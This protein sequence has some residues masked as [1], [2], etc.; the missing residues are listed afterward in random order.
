[1]EVA[2]HVSFG[3]RSHVGAQDNAGASA[4]GSVAFVGDSRRFAASAS[5]AKTGGS[6]VM[7]VIFPD[8]LAW[9]S[10]ALWSKIIILNDQPWWVLLYGLQTVT[11]A[12]LGT[13]QTERYYWKVDLINE[14]TKELS[15][16]VAELPKDATA[17]W[18]HLLLVYEGIV[19]DAV[20]FIGI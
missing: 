3:I 16:S 17:T 4:T 6:S 15:E 8:T 13:W 1:M 18:K 10:S 7:K 12:Y 20:H 14:R 5:Q 11:T 9:H 19:A 2:Q